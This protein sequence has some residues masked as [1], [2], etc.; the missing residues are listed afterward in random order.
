[1]RKSKY[2][3]AFLLIGIMLFSGCINSGPL[4]VKG[5][6]EKYNATGAYY[7]DG[8]T[9]FVHLGNVG[10]RVIEYDEIQA[11]FV[12]DDMVVEKNF[13]SLLVSRQ[14][15]SPGDEK[16]Y[17]FITN[18]SETADLYQKSRQTGYKIMF[19]LIV[20]NKGKPLNDMI[21][22]AP[23]SGYIDYPENIYSP[24]YFTRQAIATAHILQ[25]KAEKIDD[26]KK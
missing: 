5:K 14:L 18:R 1:M 20:Y 12:V 11:A 17:I 10:T 19:A 6:I 8:Y 13:N 16:Q 9:V 21:Y 25:F 4:T 24:D 26:L 23:I 15:L 7:S 3:L 22:I 2:F